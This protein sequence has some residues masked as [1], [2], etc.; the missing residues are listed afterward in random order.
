MHATGI[1]SPPASESSTRTTS[2]TRP[3]EPV[4][5]GGPAPTPIPLESR[6]VRSALSDR[7]GTR[8]VVL[9][10]GALLGLGRPP[11]HERDESS[12][13]RRR[14]TRAISAV[15]LAVLAMTLRCTLLGSSVSA[16]TRKGPRP[17]VAHSWEN[18]AAR[19]SPRPHVLAE[20]SHAH[21]RLGPL[22]LRVC[23]QRA[24]LCEG[25]LWIRSDRVIRV[26]VSGANLPL[27]VD[28]VPGRQRKARG[29]LRS[30]D[31]GGP[32]AIF[33]P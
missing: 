25:L 9:C 24:E 18:C 5:A 30:L 27:R 1:V 23:R 17:E 28:D 22:A 29:Y 12:D 31:K 11:R 21:S 26:H 33:N 16:R 8:T 20:S 32:V 7:Y 3:R 10:G 4:G 6:F 14:T 15:D 19:P 13:A 2:S